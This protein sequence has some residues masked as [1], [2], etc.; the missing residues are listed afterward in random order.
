[1]R[2]ERSFRERGDDWQ[3]S[4]SVG[5]LLSLLEQWGDKQRR[6][7]RRG[8]MGRRRG[9]EAAKRALLCALCRYGAKYV[10]Q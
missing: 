5:V 9:G 8:T 1:M 6:W 3:Q 7:R 4:A 2:E 10:C